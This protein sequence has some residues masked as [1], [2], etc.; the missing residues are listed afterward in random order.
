M[1]PPIAFVIAGAAWRAEFFLRVAQACP[2]LFRCTGVCSRSTQRRETLAKQFGVATFDTFD[3]LLASATSSSAQARAMFVVTSVPR[4]VNPAMIRQAIVAGL[5]VLSETPPAGSID[6]M[7][8]LWKDVT[9]RGGKVQ[10][11]EQLHLQPH[12]A[13][14]IALARGG[15]LGAISQA[16]VSV[17]HGYHGM[18]LIRR[19]LGIR[20]EN[21]R[22]SAIEFGSSIVEPP[23]RAG[24]PPEQRI[25]ETSQSINLL[26]FDGRR[27]G[28]LDF[29]GAQ[30]FSPIRSPR[31]VVR[32]ERGEIINDQV[33]YLKDHLTPIRAELM[34]HEAGQHGS[35]EARHLRGI[36][37]CQDWIYRNPC[38]PARLSD[39]EI[40]VGTS[41][42]KMAE[43]VRDGRPFYP[44]AEACQDTYLDLAAQQAARDRE[45]LV[46]TTQPWASP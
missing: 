44:L 21:A 33:V 7:I 40:A 43:Y 13:S 25:A 20:Y 22:I 4:D 1:N 9:A 32:G 38:A 36:Q 11:A 23:G 28:I 27:L 10:V 42:L 46:T 5:P 15:L 41:L 19:L 8:A 39:E 16:Q 18:S 3:A 26:Q 35:L 34:R 45:P 17:A 12:H 24:P 37:F 2:D 29:D 6:E 14:R 30:Y 31:V